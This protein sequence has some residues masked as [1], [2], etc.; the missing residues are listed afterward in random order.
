MRTEVR[1]LVFVLGAAALLAGSPRPAA[2]RAFMIGSSLGMVFPTDRLSDRAD[3]LGSL[4]LPG[5]CVSVHGRWGEDLAGTELPWEGA[6]GLATFSSEQESELRIIYVPITIGP[7]WD[8]SSVQ[9]LTLQ[10]RAATGVAMVA[11]NMGDRRTMYLGLLTGGAGVRRAIH[12]VAVAVDLSAG[13]HL[14]DSALRVGD[15]LPVFLVR[16]TVFAL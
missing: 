16:L 5:P 9:G 2:S 10:L 6:I 11:A 3:Y 14:P 8:V 7:V 12:D 4:L 1:I 13:V 15:L